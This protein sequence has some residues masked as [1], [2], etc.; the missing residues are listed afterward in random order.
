MVSELNNFSRIVE[1]R[2]EF[3]LSEGIVVVI[4]H[5]VIRIHILYNGDVKFL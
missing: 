3:R 4:P 5:F 1:I 2:G